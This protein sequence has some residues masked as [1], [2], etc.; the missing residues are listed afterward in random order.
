MSD[1]EEARDSGLLH[2]TRNVQVVEQTNCCNHNA[3]LKGDNDNNRMG[4]YWYHISDHSSYNQNGEGCGRK[5]GQAG[6]RMERTVQVQSD[7][8]APGLTSRPY[9]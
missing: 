1:K 4:S 2:A 6:H 3:S 5:P 9:S 8:E 7:Q